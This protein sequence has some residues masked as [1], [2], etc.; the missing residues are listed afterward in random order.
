MITLWVCRPHLYYDWFVSNV[1][2]FL[3]TFA[4]QVTEQVSESVSESVNLSCR[5]S[6]CRSDG[7]W[8]S[9][10][11]WVNQSVSQPVWV[12][13]SVPLYPPICYQLGSHLNQ[14]FS[15]FLY[16]V[17]CLVEPRASQCQPVECLFVCTSLK[18]TS[19]PNF[20]LLISNQNKKKTKLTKS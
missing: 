14:Q 10:P 17:W 12:S 16:N 15:R 11:V 13:E 8:V 3:I 20:H 2:T 6:F 9:Q 1:H 19:S 5:P 7:Q 18:L 4:K